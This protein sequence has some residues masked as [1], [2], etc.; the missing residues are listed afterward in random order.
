MGKTTRWVVLALA[1]GASGCGSETT[2][3]ATGDAAPMGSL[4][5]IGGYSA[6]ALPLVPQ[7]MN[8]AGSI[9]GTTASGAPALYSGGT[10]TTLRPTSTNGVIGVCDTSGGSHPIFWFFLSWAPSHMPLVV[11]NTA[12]TTASV[13]GGTTGY[14]LVGTAAGGYFTG[15]AA[16]R[17]SGPGAT[18]AVSIQPVAIGSRINYAYAS[19]ATGSNESGY[20]VGTVYTNGGPYPVVWN[21]SNG[22]AVLQSL[23]AYQYYA[24]RPTAISS[25]GLVVGQSGTSASTGWYAMMWNTAGTLVNYVPISNLAAVDAVSANGRLVGRVYGS[26][27]YRAW[28][29]Y[30]GSLTYLDPPSGFTSLY[31]VGVNGCGHIA[32]QGYTTSGTFSGL[33][34]SK[35]TCDSSGVVA[36]Q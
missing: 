9:A 36:A 7:G 25:A 17:W 1:V 30:Q 21:P 31:P 20:A 5:F 14:S 4:I 16:Y 6:S 12:V 18:S 33:L 35:L 19:S 8:D 27:G 15:G 11:N 23:G 10:L 29:W 32:M 2:P 26:A 13:V 3:Q 34:Y 28:T 22:Y 24:T